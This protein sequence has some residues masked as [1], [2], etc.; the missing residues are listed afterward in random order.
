M[1]EIITNEFIAYKS[2]FMQGKTDLMEALY[3]GKIVD[4]N[5]QKEEAEN[6]FTYG[7]KD[8]LDYYGK[9]VE[10]HSEDINKVNTREVIKECFAE[11]V[12]RMNAEQGKEIPI[13]KFRI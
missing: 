10:N 1:K 4:L 9:L 13:G 12:I 6:W 2:G 7:E 5:S 11:R 8:A 3:C